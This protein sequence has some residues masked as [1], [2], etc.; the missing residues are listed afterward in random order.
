MDIKPPPKKRPITTRPAPTPPMPRPAPSELSQIARKPVVRSDELPVPV[1]ETIVPLKKRSFPWWGK[2]L[3][4]IAVLALLASIC[5]GWYFFSL[6]PKASESNER[7]QRITIEKGETSTTIAAHLE[8]T[9]IIRSSLAMRLYVEM[10]GD[11]HKLQAGGYLLSTSQSVEEIVDHLVSGKTDE[12]NVRILPG[13]TLDELADDSVQGSLVQQGFSEEEIRSAY[14]ATYQHPLL[15]SKPT[16]ADLE[17]YIFPETYR[18]NSSSSL[19]SLFE[20]SFDEL[21]NRMQK[22]GTVIAF[23]ARN[24]TIHQG[25]TLASM[26]QKEVSNTAGQPQVAQVFLRRLELGQALGSDVTYLYAAKKMGVEGTPE[27]DSPYNTRKFGGLPPGP[28]ANMNYTAIQAV[29]YPAPGDFLFFVA[30]D[31]ADAGKTFFART[32]EEHQANIAAHCHV[33]CR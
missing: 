30:G 11:K 9:G 28:I 22:D 32:E 13:F 17:G 20:R 29:V 23:Q 24:L 2:L 33:L 19:Q 1:V 26:V 3:S 12:F 5:A 18:M 25:I 10:S 7:R 31:G 15:A 21:Y 6:T 14:A 4:I 27:L 8:K 16:T